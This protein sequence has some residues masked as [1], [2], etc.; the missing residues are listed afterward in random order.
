MVKSIGT[1]IIEVDRIRKIIKKWGKRF[2]DR[3]FDEEEISK[4]KDIYLHLA[5]KFAAKEAIFKTLGAGWPQISYKD[6]QIK[7]DQISGSPEVYLR[8]RAKLLA[9]RQGITSIL[10]S[11][12]HSSSYA[13]S[14]AIANKE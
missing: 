8:G 12:S 10:V 11:I 1:D 9:D 14:F 6:V 3:I 2:I 7:N 13:I 5:G 4:E